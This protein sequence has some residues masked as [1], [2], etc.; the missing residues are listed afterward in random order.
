MTDTPKPLRYTWGAKYIAL[1]DAHGPVALAA[2][3][4]AGQYDTPEWEAFGIKTC[5]ALNAHDDMLA[6]LIGLSVIAEQNLT[7]LA[8]DV[9]DGGAYA[10]MEAARWQAVLDA[11]AKATAP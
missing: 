6:A 4:P 10:K 9:Q 2:C 11:I 5:A 1:S 8:A 3:C 7:D